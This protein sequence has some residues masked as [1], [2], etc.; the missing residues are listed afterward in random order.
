MSGD[1]CSRY[2]ENMLNHTFMRLKSV[3]GGDLTSCCH[4]H[5]VLTGGYMLRG[6]L[7]FDGIVNHRKKWLGLGA[8][9]K[10]KHLPCIHA[11]FT[12][13]GVPKGLLSDAS[14]NKH[15]VVTRLLRDG[16]S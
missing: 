11:F 13:N 9:S 10:S 15:V 7:R 14:H 4:D 3:M 2:E 16:R 8:Q 6:Q 1:P 12:E 5:E